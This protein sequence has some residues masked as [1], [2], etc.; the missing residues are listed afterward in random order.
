[1]G[2]KATPTSILRRL[3]A[4]QYLKPFI[5]PPT[6]QLHLYRL[7]TLLTFNSH[8]DSL[9]LNFRR[10]KFFLSKSFPVVIWLPG[11]ACSDSVPSHRM[12]FIATSKHGSPTFIRQN[13]KRSSGYSQTW[14][15][16]ASYLP[17][18][19]SPPMLNEAPTLLSIIHPR[20]H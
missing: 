14:P 5:R 10:T 17:G 16:H 6:T 13:P 2:A 3:H 4:P 12:K 19:T 7:K 18:H 9:A 1:M 8:G 20:S 11:F 15:Q